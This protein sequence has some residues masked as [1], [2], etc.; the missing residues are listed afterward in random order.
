MKFLHLH[1]ENK[2]EGGMTIAY[3]VSED[4]TEVRFAVARPHPSK[5][6][7]YSKKIGREVAGGRFTKNRHG[8][9]ELFKKQPEISPVEAI[10]HR[11]GIVDA[12]GYA[13]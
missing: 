7:N 1:N 4:Q 3:E 10:L 2:V 5:Q 11:L 9:V 12:A 8:E 6:A 13:P